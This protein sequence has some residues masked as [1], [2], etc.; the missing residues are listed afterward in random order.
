MEQ[1]VLVAYGSANG[2][3][4]EMAEAVAGV[5]RRTE[6]TAEVLPARSVTDLDRYGAVVVGGALYAGR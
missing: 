3:T 2:S 6:I 4:E 1:K 5:L